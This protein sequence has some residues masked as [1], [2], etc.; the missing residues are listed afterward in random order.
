MLVAGGGIAGCATALALHRAGI[1]SVVLEARAD[2]GGTG[3]WDE[4]GGWFLTLAANGVRA[5]RALGAGAALDRVSGPMTS[6]VL[7]DADGTERARRPLG[8]GDPVGF[9]H[10]TRAALISALR[11]EVERRGIE[12]VP[13]ARV[14]AVEPDGCGVRVHAGG[15]TRTGAVL[16]GA[17]GVGSAVRAVVDQACPAPRPTGQ[18]VYFGRTP[19]RPFDG[20]GDFH[21]VAGAA[22]A[23]A[24]IPTPAGPTWWFARAGPPDPDGDPGRAP[25]AGALAA[26]S[27]S[28]VAARLVEATAPDDVGAVDPHDLPYTGTWWRGRA[29][30][31]GDAAHAASPATGH[32]ST[33]ACEDAVVLARALHGSDL[34]DERAVGAALARYQRLRRG[35]CQANVVASAEMCGSPVPDADPGSRID[36][37]EL[38][39]HLDWGEPLPDP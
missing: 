6:F 27:G 35:R 31:V 17:D 3:G 32:G 19:D 22:Q 14:T 13:G 1:E 15:D 23:F 10:L 5:V 8:G 36:D 37:A 9:R 24:A 38:H 2:G 7:H 20:D 11:S 16:V 39:V 33:L 29:V 34:R 12:V 28:G 4:L 18:R 25:R 21:V 30:L 26:L